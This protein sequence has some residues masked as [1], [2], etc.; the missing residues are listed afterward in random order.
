MAAERNWV[1][2]RCQKCDGV[3]LFDANE[4]GPGE[5]HTQCLH[6]NA[7]TEVRVPPAS[8]SAAVAEEPPPAAE[9]LDSEPIQPAIPMARRRRW[10][11]AGLAVGL[12]ILIGCLDVVYE[13][14]KREHVQITAGE[15]ETIP[16]STTYKIYE[17]QGITPYRVTVHNGARFAINNI[18]IKWVFYD[19]AGTALTT[20]SQTF[21]ESMKP[22]EDKT[23]KMPAWSL[24]GETVRS[25]AT[26]RS[27]GRVW[28]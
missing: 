8:K 22:G 18:R 27:V 20:Y 1:T 13:R 12:L 4:L 24:P 25:R 10:I 2:C 9:A 21:H 26:V 3:F 11:Q 7:E 16:G 28:R 17:L 23:F 5:T 15:Y 19:K 6:C 14:W